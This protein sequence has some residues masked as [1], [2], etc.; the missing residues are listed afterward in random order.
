MATALLTAI[1]EGLPSIARQLF[2]ESSSAHVRRRRHAGRVT[3]R[4]QLRTFD[5]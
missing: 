3:T 2:K 1:H 5:V 4:E